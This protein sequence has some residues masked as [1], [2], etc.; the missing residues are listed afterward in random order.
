M[1]WLD[2]IVP[3]SVRRGEQDRK[4]SV[5]EGVWHKCV[6]CEAVLYR[7]EL[8]R[9]LDVCPKCAHHLRVSA[10]RRLDQFLDEEPRLEIGADIEPVDVLKFRGSQRY[11]DQL[12]QKQKATGEHDALVVIMGR[13]KGIA[14]VSAAFLPSSDCRARSS[15]SKPSTCACLSAVRKSL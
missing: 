4:S 5:P 9:G 12:A 14:L 13:V 1:S 11:R 3:A 2:K 10:R 7:P 8:D 15:S 6:K